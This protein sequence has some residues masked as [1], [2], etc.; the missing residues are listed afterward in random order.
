MKAGGVDAR[1]IEY[2]VIKKISSRLFNTSAVS[3]LGPCEGLDIDPI[4][5]FLD[6]GIMLA[7]GFKGFRRGHPNGFGEH[8]ISLS[9]E[10]IETIQG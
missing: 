2:E 1:L 10:L 7:L 6:G 3:N 8:L 5:E 4:G 9:V